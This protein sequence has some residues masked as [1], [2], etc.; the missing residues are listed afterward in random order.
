MFVINSIVI[1]IKGQVYTSINAV[2]W[3]GERSRSLDSTWTQS[4]LANKKGQ[5]RKCPSSYNNPRLT[6]FSI[7]INHTLWKYI[8]L[9]YNIYKAS[10][11]FNIFPNPDF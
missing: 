9:V 11:N 5:V 10:E 3:T 8:Y 6:H 7:Y 4:G 1:Q 2:A